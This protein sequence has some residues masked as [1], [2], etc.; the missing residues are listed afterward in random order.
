M[1][2]ENARLQNDVN[3]YLEWLQNT[4]NSLW[5]MEKQNEQLKDELEKEKSNKLENVEEE[6]QIKYNLEYVN[7]GGDT[8]IIDENT[9][10]VFSVNNITV[11]KTADLSITIPNSATEYQEGIQAGFTKTFSLGDKNYQLIV[12]SLDYVFDCYSVKIKEL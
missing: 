7:I 3:K 5:Y 6:S 10:V 9:G 1:E 11:R 4:P 12:T 2:V 8:G